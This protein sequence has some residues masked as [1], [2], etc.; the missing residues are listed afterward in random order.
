[1]GAAMAKFRIF[2]DS[3]NCL[4]VMSFPEVRRD[5][6][7]RVASISDMEKDHTKFVLCSGYRVEV[8]LSFGEI[9]SK[10]HAGHGVDFEGTQYAPKS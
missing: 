7:I 9:V 6:E 5:E 4:A 2:V 1:M 3:E 8:N 10:F